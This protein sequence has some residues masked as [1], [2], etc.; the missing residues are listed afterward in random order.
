M[1]NFLLKYTIMPFRFCESLLCGVF[2][3]TLEEELEVFRVNTGSNPMAQ[4]G[5]PRFRPAP[6]EALAHLLDFPFDSL[7]STIKH[8]GIEVSLQGDI[9]AD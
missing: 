6:T 3:Y 1:N 4:V 7:F 9:R 2:V 8:A 5:Y